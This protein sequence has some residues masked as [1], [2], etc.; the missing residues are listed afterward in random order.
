MIDIA[1]ALA[2]LGL[3]IAAWIIT[4]D[5]T[6]V[7]IRIFFA[8]GV[9]GV[10]VQTVISYGWG[11]NLRLL[12]VIVLVLFVI[13]TLLSLKQRS[14][15]Q[16][17]S[18]QRQF[19]G[20]FLPAIAIGLFLLATRLV[21][22]E[23]PELLTGLGYLVN[24]PFAED[25]AKWLNLSSQLASGRDLVF[26]GYAGGPLVMLMAIVAPFIAVASLVLFGGVNEVAVAVTTVIGLQFLFIALVPFAL[27]PL[28][29]SRIPPAP[30]SPGAASF[31][32]PLPL[33]WVG[34]VVV[35]LASSV[36]TVYGHLSLQLVFLPMILWTAVFLVMPR[37]RG[38]LVLSSL[39]IVPLAS[40]WFPL[41]GL[42]A[43]VL[44]AVGLWTLVRR[45]WWYLGAAIVTAVAASD[46]ILSPAFYLLGIDL[47]AVSVD[48]DL[49][50]E[51][52][53]VSEVAPATLAPAPAQQAFA[54]GGGTEIAEPI[55]GGLALISIVAVIWWFGQ[56][57]AVHGWR[58][59]A[60]FAPLGLFG[61]YLI[62]VITVDGLT[63]ATAPNYGAQKMTFAYVIIALGATL[64]IALAA[65]QQ[66]AK[67]MTLLRWGA[68]FAI[69]MLLAIDGLLPRALSSLS[70]QLWPRVNL[71]NPQ[72]WALAEVR[73]VAEQPIVQLPLACLHAGADIAI[74]GG[75]PDGQRAYSCSRLLIGLNGLEGR[76]GPI[77]EL[78]STDWFGN[79]SSWERYREQLASDAYGISDRKL[80]FMG[81]DGSVNGVGTIREL[82]SRY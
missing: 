10:A 74:P 29:T 2:F 80:I 48:P 8:L 49:V 46:A 77:P 13:I 67:G 65:L 64:P 59:F 27:A 41:L 17:R 81:P 30:R 11:V 66:R 1:F 21:A 18:L 82:L 45:M 61:A 28:V 60:P 36:L 56:A 43:V 62:A 16:E 39:A 6:W 12:Q 38:A 55:L 69:I 3:P 25:S 19:V 50:V 33:V 20:V 54:A 35:G 79:T 75:Q 53:V 4:R 9:A 72:Y 26:A 47:P 31:Q 34:A 44:L 73:P 37:N 7:A 22:P 24:H 78:L 32:L 51:E 68:S 23:R 58:Q 52:V 76:A 71:E 40:A 14:G 15:A 63:T 70:P 42:T 5:I 57:R